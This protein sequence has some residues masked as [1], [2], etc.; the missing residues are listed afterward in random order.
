MG[1]VVLSMFLVAAA[2]CKTAESLTP[3][4]VAARQLNRAPFGMVRDGHG[5]MRIEPLPFTKE[6]PAGVPDF[7]SWE[8]HGFEGPVSEPAGASHLW[9]RYAIAAG[10]CT[11]GEPCTYSFTYLFAAEETYS[12]AGRMIAVRCIVTQ[13]G[14]RMEI[15]VWSPSEDVT[16][17]YLRESSGWR[18]VTARDEIRRVASLVEACVRFHRAAVDS[19]KRQASM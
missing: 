14:R 9:V 17:H 13:G 19:A 18:V 4:E 3:E 6:R 5:A 10:L 2:S 8:A 15:L 16:T 1:T 11:E 12:K 7:D